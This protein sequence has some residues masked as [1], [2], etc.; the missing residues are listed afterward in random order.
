MP[1]VG[2]GCQYLGFET[3]VPFKLLILKPAGPPLTVDSKFPSAT[4]L[5][6]FLIGSSS[7]KQSSPVFNLFRPRPFYIW[8]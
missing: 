8:G 7:K 6:I 1:S 2:I 4:K 5:Q 3:V